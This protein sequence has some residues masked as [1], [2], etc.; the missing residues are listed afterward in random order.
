MTDFQ[1]GF[2]AGVEA[3]AKAA[4]KSWYENQW[5]TNPVDQIVADIRALP[6]PVAMP[7]LDPSFTAGI[8]A[9]RAAL[10]EYFRVWPRERMTADIISKFDV[11]SHFLRPPAA[12]AESENDVWV[13]GE[14]NHVIG[15]GVS[16]TPPL[17]ASEPA[18]AP[19]EENK[20]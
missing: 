18:G 6:I 12:P 7:A 16:K 13:D 10:V 9:M 14:G 15:A 5:M 19:S 2:A 3:A 20:K 11:P 17:S 4:R 1:Q 8:E